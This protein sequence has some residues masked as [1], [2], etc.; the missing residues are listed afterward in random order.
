MGRTA[1]AKNKPKDQSAKVAS[2]KEKTDA[3]K[4]PAAKKK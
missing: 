3:K 2:K 4:K 1:G